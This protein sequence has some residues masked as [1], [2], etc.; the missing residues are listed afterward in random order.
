M[1]RE[2]ALANVLE[3]LQPT[4]VVVGS[5]GFLS[6]EIFE[7]RKA[8]GQSH[9]SDFLTVG[10]MGHSPAIALGIAIDKAD[11]QII[12]LEGDGSLIMH[13]GTMATVGI[14]KLKNFKQV[15]LN[16]GVHDSVGAQPT[17]AFG[18]DFGKI[19]LA[20]GYKSAFYAD[21]LES[22]KQNVVKLRQAEGPALMEVRV[23]HGARP[24]LGR[25]TQSCTAS[26]EDFMN[27]LKK[28]NL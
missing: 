28:K 14:K 12:N 8:K 1:T 20:C 7:L 4:D 19:A 9:G 11:R 3:N 18:L 15:V 21:T 2:E 23:K 16:N 24:D 5:T 17:G 22:L 10:S 25:P 26:K 27:F 13:M 6:R